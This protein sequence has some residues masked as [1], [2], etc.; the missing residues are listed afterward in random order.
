MRSKE[1]FKMGE[2]FE[3]HKNECFGI[4][5][6][7][8]KSWDAVKLHVQRIHQ[9]VNESSRGFI[10]VK[11]RDIKEQYGDTKGQQIINKRTA[12]GWYYADPDFPDDPDEAC[13]KSS[14]VLL[15]DPR[16]IF[17]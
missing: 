14:V 10:S 3:T 5:L 16:T 8:N 9:S 6:D 15:L 13:L 11:G 2:Y 17:F 12:D 4:W 1:R 7:S